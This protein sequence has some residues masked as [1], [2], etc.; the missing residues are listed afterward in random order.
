[1]IK[2]IRVIVVFALRKQ[3]EQTDSGSMAV[4]EYILVFS[5]ESSFTVKAAVSLSASF[6][7]LV[8]TNTDHT[9][10]LVGLSLESPL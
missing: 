4:L 6:C 1:M 9:L 2:H 10:P 7:V 3:K 5:S 8:C